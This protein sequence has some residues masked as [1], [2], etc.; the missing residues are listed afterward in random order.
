MTGRGSSSSQPSFSA[1]EHS[2][3][4][5]HFTL[6]IFPDGKLLL[7]TPDAIGPEMLRRITEM[8]QAWLDGKQPGLILGSCVV[9][10][11]NQVRVVDVEVAGVA[12]QV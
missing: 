2:H 12:D 7:S 3:K 5:P 1:A 9:V 4:G 11:A 10:V 6:T 8:F